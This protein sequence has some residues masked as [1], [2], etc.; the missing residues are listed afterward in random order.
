VDVV[1]AIT[2]FLFTDIEGSSQLWERYP[3]RMRVALAGG[4][5]PDGVTLR[6]LGAAANALAQ[7]HRMQ[8]DLDAA[9]PLYE[10][11][12]V[13]ARELDDRESIAVGLLNL[14]MVAIARGS[15]E[16]A[17]DRLLEAT[18]I[19]LEIGS[20]PAGQSAL[21]VAAGLD[22]LRG[23]W[24]RSAGFFGSAEAQM[25]QTGIKR[26]P[27]DEGFLAPLIANARKA[28]GAPAFSAAES[29]GCRL[30][31]DVAIADARAWLQSRF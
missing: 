22:A 19:A 15:G 18:V 27:A 7:L 30:G 26:D 20:K 17:G 1:S 21:E 28:L 4:R 8:G 14:A 23:E 3:E 12:L 2:T 6:E 25:A 5:L 24:E 13:L 9:E 11:M 10:Q 16:R 31:Y 29:A